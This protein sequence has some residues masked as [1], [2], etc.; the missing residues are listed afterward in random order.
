MKSTDSISLPL[1]EEPSIQ[2]TATNVDS[3]PIDIVIVNDDA[4]T[5]PVMEDENGGSNNKGD[6]DTISEDDTNEDDGISHGLLF[7]VVFII[8]GCVIFVIGLGAYM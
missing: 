3:I 6:A 4:P 7:L 8:A 1:T 2:D 5:P